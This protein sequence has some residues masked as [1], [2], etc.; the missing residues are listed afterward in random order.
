M[1]PGSA[2]ENNDFLLLSVYFIMMSIK[3][4]IFKYAIDFSKKICRE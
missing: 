1:F 4:T 3:K 2:A